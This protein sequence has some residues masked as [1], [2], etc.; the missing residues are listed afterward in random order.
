MAVGESIINGGKSLAAGI[1]YLASRAVHPAAYV[2]IGYASNIE[3]RIPS[4]N[5]NSFRPNW[6]QIG[7][8]KL[9][10]LGNY[11]SS[12]TQKLSGAG[13]A[14]FRLDVPAAYSS[15]QTAFK[16]HSFTVGVAATW[17]LTSTVADM[18]LKKTPVT[19]NRP[20]V[21]G[22][23]AVALGA[24]ATWAVYNFGLEQNLDPKV[25]SDIAFKVASI[26]GSWK[27]VN[28]SSQYLLRALQ[29]SSETIGA[30]VSGTCRIGI[31]ILSLLEWRSMTFANKSATHD[32][33][34]SAPTTTKASPLPKVKLLPEKEPTSPDTSADEVPKESSGRGGLFSWFSSSSGSSTK[35]SHSPATVSKLTSPKGEEV[36]RT[37]HLEEEEEEDSGSGSDS[38]L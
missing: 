22:I 13:R 35:G 10:Q 33:P 17:G 8:M 2:V 9:N 25:F 4:V 18:I 3:K 7:N 15:V 1:Y 36:D 14:I 24:G 34:P 31:G 27:V 20:I 11:S 29:R 26:G 23:V 16:D 6:D 12:V 38:G 5:L 32:A 28:V 21:R 30:A 37:D 19:H